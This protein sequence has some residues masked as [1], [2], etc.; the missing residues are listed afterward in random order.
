MSRDMNIL[1]EFRDT[2]G[3]IGDLREELRLHK[4]NCHHRHE[5]LSS[6]VERIEHQLTSRP[7]APTAAPP[8]APEPEKPVHPLAA[9]F[10]AYSL[11]RFAIISGILVVISPAQD[12]LTALETAAKI[13]S[14][15]R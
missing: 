7:T 5:I 2:D 11:T 10:S 6:R 15:L 13:L 12:V 4:Q 3:R 8:P 9:L 14:A 1:R